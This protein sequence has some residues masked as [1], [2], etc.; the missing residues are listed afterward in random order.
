MKKLSLLLSLSIVFFVSCK[1]NIIEKSELNTK[2]TAPVSAQ[3]MSEIVVP[4]GFKWETSRDVAV[5]ITSNDIRFGNVLH[6]VEIYSANPAEG[7]IKLAE[8]GLTPTKS[9]DANISTASFIKSFYIVKVA[10]DNS[11]LIEKFDITG[12]HLTAEVKV[13]S[14]Q[15]TSLGKSAGPD[16]SSGCTQTITSNNQNLNINNGDVVCVTGNNITIGFNANGGTI[17]ICGTNV[18]LQNA[19]LSNSSSLIV[20]STGSASFSNLNMNGSATTITNYGTMQVSNSFSPGGSIVNHG[21]IT[22]TG[23]YNLNTNAAQVNNGTILVGQSMNV[24]NGVTQTNNGYIET[25]NDFKV[26]GGAT[27]INNCRLWAKKEF[28]NNSLTQNYGLV[29]ANTNSYLNGGSVFNMYDGAMLSTQHAIVN[30]LAKGF[31]TTSVIKVSNNTLINSGGAITHAISYCD[32]NGIETNNGT[33]SNGA[34]LTCN[35]YIPTSTCNPIGNGSS[36]ITDTDGDGVADNL[37][38]FPN[39]NTKAFCNTYGLATVAFEDLWPHKG[40]YDM[41]DVVVNYTYNVI[42]NAANVVVR[43]EANYTLRATGGSFNNGFGVQFPVNNNLV[44]DVVGATLEGNQS[45]AVLVIFNNMRNQMH[46]WN[47]VPN[48]ATSAPV[49]YQVSFNVNNGPTLANFGLGS[50]NPFIWNGTAGF[51]RGYEVHLP[52]K[53][54]TDLANLSLL[55][56]GADAS[57]IATGDTYVSK[58]GRYPWAINIPVAFDYPVEKADINTAY[59]KFATWVSSGGTQFTD[60]YTAQNGYRNVANIY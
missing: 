20:T 18:T 9:F 32:A 24:N 15:K 53:L 48:A 39:D 23:D 5:K 52:G 56:T 16:C 10:P 41:N 29:Q 51:G 8:G 17:R 34:S 47:T 50:Y 1:Q 33:I 40:D 58:N 6:K 30:G 38:C 59:T 22:T 57:N 13:S 46:T 27:F 14:T 21:T 4:D 35:T 44:T 37:D 49:N 28:H 25:I 11:K 19:N 7:G 43:V 2:T 26:N 55:G 31:G 42:T 60:W 54:P 36:P 3:K 45:K 12:N